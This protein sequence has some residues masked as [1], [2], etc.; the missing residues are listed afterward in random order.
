MKVKKIYNL[1]PNYV[2]INYLLKIEWI[3]KNNYKFYKS[4]YY[5]RIDT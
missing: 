2:I 5:G 1:I 4:V 3:L